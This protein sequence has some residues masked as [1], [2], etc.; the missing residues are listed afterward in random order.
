MTEQQADVAAPS[1]TAP[2]AN[3]ATPEV[4]TDTLAALRDLSNV[5]GPALGEQI[6]QEVH[7]GVAT[8]LAAH[9]ADVLTATGAQVASAL[10]AHR[11][12]L[13]ANFAAQR[14]ALRADVTRLLRDA[15]M[16]TRAQVLT[17]IAVVGVLLAVGVAIVVCALCGNHTAQGW[18]L[19]APTAFLAAILWISRAYME[20]QAP[21]L[22][23]TI[24]MGTILEPA[25][26]A[27]AQSAATPAD[28]EAAA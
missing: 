11:A 4:I 7:S 10:E 1:G 24:G 14:D 27:P 2:Q 12:E 25:R 28:A 20:T 3:G 22:P 17:A 9:K 15:R 18:I 16:A 26:T 23:Y 6:R 8:A 19:A 5:L 21:H 13:A